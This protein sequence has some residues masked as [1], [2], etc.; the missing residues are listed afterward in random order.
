MQARQTD[1]I[2][3]KRNLEIQDLVMSALR[4]YYAGQVQVRWVVGGA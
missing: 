4:D 2:K 3:Y 1:A